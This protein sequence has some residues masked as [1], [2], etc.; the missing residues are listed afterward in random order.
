M[1]VENDRDEDAEDTSEA[2]SYVVTRDDAS[3]PL[4]PRSTR[5]VAEKIAGRIHGLYDG[6]EWL[7]PDWWVELRD[8]NPQKPLGSNGWW[9]DIHAG[10]TLWIP[11]YWPMPESESASDA[12]DASGPLDFLGRLNPFGGAV[13]ERVPAQHPGNAPSTT[14]EPEPPEF[15]SSWD[16]P[17]SGDSLRRYTGPRL[18]ITR[19]TY[20]VKKGDSPHT[21]AQTCGAATRPHWLTELQRVNPQKPVESGIGNW[22]KLE[23]GETINLPDAWGAGNID[24]GEDEAAGP[25]ADWHALAEVEPQAPYFAPLAKLFRGTPDPEGS[26]RSY[27]TTLAPHFEAVAPGEALGAVLEL[28]AQGFYVALPGASGPVGWRRATAAELNHF[29]PDALRQLGGLTFWVE[30]AS[31]I[32]PPPPSSEGETGADDAGALTDRENLT[33]QTYA[34]HRGEGMVDIARKFG[35]APRPR[36]FAELRD[37]NPTKAIAVDPK[38]KKQVGWR[39]LNPGDIVNIPDVWAAA[40]SPHA[41][42]APGGAPSP[43][44]Y[45]GLQ[46]FPPL[47]EHG[48]YP[49]PTAPPGTTPAAATVDPGTILRVQGVLVAFRHAH[50]KE[51]TPANFGEGL[52]VS[53]DCLGVLTPRTQQALASFQTWSN[54]QGRYPLDDPRSLRTDGVLDPA[55]IAALDSFSAQAL[56]GLA[57]RPPVTTIPGGLPPG[58]ADPNLRSVIGAATTAVGDLARPDQWADVF[59]ASSPP[60]G[61][62]LPPRKV[63]VPAPLHELPDV[64]NRN[65]AP[66]VPS[67]PPGAPHGPRGPRRRRPE[68][69]TTT[70]ALQVPQEVDDRF[71][72]PGTRLPEETPPARVR[73]ETPAKSRKDNDG[74]M[75]PVALAGLSLV[76]GII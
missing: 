56:G 54:Q 47:P 31:G 10:E 9:R 63:G 33:H 57:Q 59:R 52:P 64:L 53:P 71:G 4:S 6:R 14:L 70:A 75:L 58:Q 48:A 7:R 60:A 28:S 34:V 15:P 50:P 11:G 66:G 1:I 12:D 18:N 29:Q 40:D 5:Q 68:G 26:W 38:T 41:R 3:V 69:P 8:V 42:P 35:A 73:E 2:R 65:A 19:R 32:E 45:L 23:P 43:S 27:G 25:D 51:M 46:T 61:P 49:S 30:P 17:P 44:P 22:F 21:I 39:S 72:P 20:V 67:L 36:W 62:A 76:S 16:S 24:T 13:A 74:V 37:A 55:T